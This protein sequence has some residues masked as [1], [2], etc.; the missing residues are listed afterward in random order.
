MSV[1]LFD[2][3]VTLLKADA[4]G[5]VES[6]EERS[7][8][9]E[10]YVREAEMELGRKRARLETLREE[11]KRLSHNL[12]RYE[13]EIRSLDEDVALAMSGGKDDLARF[14]IRRLLRRQTLAQALREHIA[15]RR[16][17]SADLGERLAQQEAQ[18]ETLRGRVRAEVAREAAGVLPCMPPGE[19]GVADEEVEIELLRRRAARGGGR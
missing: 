5:I 17:E 9:L 4:H 3:I 12:S 7:L 11:E 2:R 15:E 13:D 14:A 19:A 8:L 16:A 6:L 1:R 10:Q 18:F